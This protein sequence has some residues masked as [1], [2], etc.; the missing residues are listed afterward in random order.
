MGPISGATRRMEAVPE[1][2]IW[3]GAR[4]GLCM[5]TLSGAL[6]KHIISNICGPRSVAD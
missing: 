1:D 5:L 4:V 2:A 6:C 3:V